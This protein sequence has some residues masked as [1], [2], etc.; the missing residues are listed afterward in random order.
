MRFK[1]MYLTEMSMEQYQ[2]KGWYDYVNRIPML[3]SAVEVL[4]ILDKHGKTFIVGGS[5]RDLVI[6]E[7]EPHDI[8]I[9]TSVSINRIEELF[10][11]H[12]IGKSKT[13]GIVAINHNGYTF[14]IANFRA[15]GEY[16]DGRRPESVQIGVSFEEDAARRDFTFNSMGIDSEGNI[17]DYF[18][19]HKDI[20]NKIL[21]TVGDPQQR[22]S[23]DYLRL[24]RAS[25]FASR[26]GFNIEDKTKQAM[27]DNAHNI[28]KIAPERI[29]QELTKMASESGE[30]FARAIQELDD[31]GIL[32][33]ILPEI[34]ALKGLEHPKIHHPEGDVWQHTLAALKTNK[35]ADPIVNLS[36]LMHDIGKKPAQFYK[37]NKVK[38]YGH[39]EKG[40]ALVNQIA[41][42]LK[43]DNATRESIIF[44]TLN[45]MKMYDLLKMSNAKIYKLITDKN[46]KV[47]Y[48]VA[49]ADSQ[50]RGSLFDEKEWQKLVDKVEE[51][52]ERY[53]GNENKQ[54]DVVKLVN[55]K[56]V[57]DI[58]GIKGSPKV[59]EV[60][61]KTIDFIINSNVDIKDVNK[62]KEFIL[63]QK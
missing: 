42:R 48:Y 9:A 11:V 4:K 51:L 57:M 34:T 24:M 12:D 39:A 28:T 27:K 1:Q 49:L 62:I 55:G 30:K 13:F 50:S 59:G 22:F 38:Y 53:S 25:R 21:R 60:I 40:I 41:D 19:G 37:D 31:A 17:I 20:K 47:L 61:R 43:L 52:L 32:Q 56:L 33:H 8:D 18:D 29:A 5:V 36:I 15:D 45:H 63:S 44:A 10:K 7:K 46:W 58:L 26:L 2:Y 16:L 3:K 23:E 6:G 35:V 54:N 14:E